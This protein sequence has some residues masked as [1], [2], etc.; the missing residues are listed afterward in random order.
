MNTNQHSRLNKR[1]LSIVGSH[2]G[3]RA[4]E[5]CAVLTSLFLEIEP[6]SIKL[7]IIEMI[8]NHEIIEI[9]YT[10]PTGRNESI[11]LPSG[12]EFKGTNDQ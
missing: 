5:L 6:Q 10:L 2:E 1:I 3:I 4:T 8:A 7:V 9:E 11:L 12:S